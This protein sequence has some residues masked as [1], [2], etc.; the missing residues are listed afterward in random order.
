MGR[1]ALPIFRVQRET[2][3][4]SARSVRSCHG[5][6][7]SCVLTLA[8]LQVGARWHRPPG[9]SQCYSG[10]RHAVSGGSPG[11]SRAPLGSQVQTWALA[12]AHYYQPS[13]APP[14]VEDYICSLQ[15]ILTALCMHMERPGVGGTGWGK[16]RTTKRAVSRQAGA[17]CLSGFFLM[18]NESGIVGNLDTQSPR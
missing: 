17:Q 3:I 18:D 14:L 9:C 7:G 13:V 11:L 1:H 12:A 16:Q 2:G 15:S 5:C 6:W 10:F 4:G 8:G